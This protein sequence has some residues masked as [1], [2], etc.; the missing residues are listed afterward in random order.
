LESETEFQTAAAG[1]GNGGT[2]GAAYESFFQTRT[3]CFPFGIISKKLLKSAPG[4]AI[5]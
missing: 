5:T 1:D 3:A 4:F 2:G